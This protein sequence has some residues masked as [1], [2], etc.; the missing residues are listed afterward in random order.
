MGL[1][2]GIEKAQSSQGG[3]YVMPGV[4][5]ALWVNAVKM[6]KSQESN[7]NLFI[8]EIDILNSKVE[9]REAGTTMSWVANLL[10]KPTLGNIKNFIGAAMNRDE[11][12]ISERI[13]EAVVTSDNP[14][15]GQLV[16]CD[17]TD[18]ITKGNKK[19]FTKCIWSAVAP[20]VQAEAKT[21]HEA[22]GFKTE[23]F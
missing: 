20:E 11:A 16:R 3:I 21:F 10:H 19:P 9:G 13:A 5:P 14:L 15:Q 4:Y 22:A 23:P 18:I 17:A 7:A 12:D 8:V 1:F 6:I 2:E